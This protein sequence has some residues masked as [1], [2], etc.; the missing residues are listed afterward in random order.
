MSSFASYIHFFDAGNL[1]KVESENFGRFVEISYG[2]LR[3][4]DLLHTGVVPTEP[5]PK[6]FLDLTG[7]IVNKGDPCLA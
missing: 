6:L 1:I 5:L 2:P 7:L 4:T 3:A